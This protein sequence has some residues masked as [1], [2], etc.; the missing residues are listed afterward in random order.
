MHRLAQFWQ[1]RRD[2]QKEMDASIARIADTELLQDRPYQKKNTV[3]IT[4][5]F[6]V[7]SLSPQS[8]P[9]DRPGSP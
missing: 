9:A 6:T 7:E 3:R 4:G 5:P 1:A 8:C 2:R